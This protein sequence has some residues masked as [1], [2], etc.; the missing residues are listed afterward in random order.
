MSA[1]KIY[2]TIGKKNL[3]PGRIHDDFGVVVE[4]HAYAVVTKLVAK[5]IFV[6]IVDP[7]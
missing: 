4:E 2:R 5:S 3:L 6:R 1:G 7:T